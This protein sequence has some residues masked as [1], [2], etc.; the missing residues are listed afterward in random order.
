V[1]DS[2]MIIPNVLHTSTIQLMI[3]VLA[4]QSNQM[5]ATWVV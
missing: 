1:F 5:K 2:A 4:G 3:D